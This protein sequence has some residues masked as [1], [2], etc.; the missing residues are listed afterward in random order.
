MLSPAKLLKNLE[1]A[2]SYKMVVTCGCL[3]EF[4]YQT[5]SNMRNLDDLRV[6]I[7][8]NITKTSGICTWIVHDANVI[9][10]NIDSCNHV[11][12]SVETFRNKVSE[13]KARCGGRVQNNTN[14]T[15]PDNL[16]CGAVWQLSG[17]SSDECHNCTWIGSY[18]CMTWV[19]ACSNT[20]LSSPS[21]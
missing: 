9:D 5:Y 2:S 14:Q 16:D 10:L 19:I 3:P 4:P 21:S 1:T 18:S 7:E 13:V 8:K 11:E 15:N 17:A 6:P 20:L 12:C